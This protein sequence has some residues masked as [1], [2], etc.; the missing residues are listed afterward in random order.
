MLGA[1]I[2]SPEMREAAELARRAALAASERPQ[3]RPLFAGH[4]ELAWPDEPHL[5]LWHAQSLLR[6]FR[7]D[8][9]VAALLVEG[10]R[11]V[12]ALVVHA[13]TG[14]IPAATLQSSRAWPDTEWNAAVESLRTRGLVAPDALTLTD[15]GRAHRDWVEQRTDELMRPAYEP[16]GIDGCERLGE[17]ARHF[18]RAIIESGGLPGGAPNPR[19]R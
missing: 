10:L 2:G 18:S 9:H 17:V 14:D 16:L 3:G 19:S 11:G 15:A 8:G 12:E 13:A 1:T 7:G 6:E 4:A 5:V